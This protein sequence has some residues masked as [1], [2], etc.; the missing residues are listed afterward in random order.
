VR[1]G[2]SSKRMV[3]PRCSP[4]P[5]PLRFVTIA[6]LRETLPSLWREFSRNTYFWVTPFQGIFGPS[7]MQNSCLSVGFRI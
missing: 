2:Q 6:H 5:L 7:Y 4:G 3:T 1:A